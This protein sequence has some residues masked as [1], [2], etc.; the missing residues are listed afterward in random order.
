MSKN[1]KMFKSKYSSVPRFDSGTSKNIKINKS[2][3]SVVILVLFAA[4]VGG[5]FLYMGTGYKEANA[6]ELVQGAKFA[7]GITVNKVDIGGLTYNEALEKL[8]PVEFTKMTNFK[9]SIIINDNKHEINGDDINIDTNMEDT[10]VQAITI[11]Q[12]GNR[13]QRKKE[14]KQVKKEGKDFQLRYTYDNDLMGQQLT[15]IQKKTGMAAQDASVKIEGGEIIYIEGKTGIKIDKEKLEEDVSAGMDQGFEQ[16]EIQAQTLEVS[17]S[18]TVQDLKNRLVKKSGTST[19]FKSSSA[20]RV[21]NVVKAAGL[22][23]GE[24]IPAGKTFSINSVLGARTSDNGWSVATAISSGKYIDDVGGGV[25][26]V[27]STL[28]NSAVKAGLEVVERRPHTFPVSYLPVGQ[29]AAISTGGPDLKLKNNYDFP[30]YIVAYASSSSKTLD[31]MIYG[32]KNEDGG[33]YVFKS[34]EIENEQPS[35]KATINV[36][37]NLLEGEYVEIKPRKNRIVVERWLE[38]VIDGKTVRT[39]KM[40]NDTYAAFNGEYAVGPGTETDSKTGKPKG[41]KVSEEYLTKKR[42]TTKESTTTK[43][44]TEEETTEETTKDSVSEQEPEDDE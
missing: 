12:T 33:S 17:P 23:N 22:L 35:G 34:N 40:S 5:Y 27:S 43:K 18:I 37:N 15:A 3:L 9:L 8:D 28:Y 29:D 20:S 21:A 39:E 14:L 1:K 4:L 36:N 16:F 7:E 26:Q 38:Y 11:G 31:V 32:P 44:E 10:L 6:Q 19:E 24:M 13:K 41:R 25:C 42:E 30:I 2:R